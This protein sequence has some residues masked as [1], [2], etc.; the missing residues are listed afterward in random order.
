MSEQSDLFGPV[1]AV[2]P[3]VVDDSLRRLAA[4]VPPRVRLGTSSWS[5]P[6]WHKLVFDRP[7]TEKE[8]ARDGLAAYAQHPLFRT[9]AVDRGHYAVVDRATC[10]RYRDQTPD[11]FRFVF[12]ALD[13]IMTP[14]LHRRHGARDGEKNPRFLDAAFALDVTAPILE[15][16]GGKL[17]VLLFQAPPFDVD[18][19][20]GAGFVVDKLHRFLQ[21]LPRERHFRVAVELRNPV[22][23][24]KHL[25]DALADVDVDPCLS[26]R[27]GM[28]AVHL[29]AKA[30][31]APSPKALIIRWLL[32]K[33]LSWD[34]A[35]KKYDPYDALVDEDADTRF[36]IS[37]LI[38]SLNVETFVIANN[39]AEGSSPLTL[40]KLAW[41]LVDP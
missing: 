7:T 26:E 19:A 2:G 31:L 18:D 28:P 22:F 39:K 9:V 3:A 5:F 34:E 32:H 40:Q 12:K 8:L 33:G 29:Q 10:E 14:R 13:E 35:E 23:L 1:A 11:D 37:G 17:G 21:A 24:S 20:G 16:L 41:E 4:R 27:T 30:L 15:G 36:A 38:R 6:G 25:R